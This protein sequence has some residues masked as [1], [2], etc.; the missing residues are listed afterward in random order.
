MIKSVLSGAVLATLL[1]VQP[2]AAQATRFDA[3]IAAEPLVTDV[4][5]RPHGPRPGVRPGFRGGPRFGYRGGGPRYGYR[6]GPRYGYGGGYYRH[7]RGWG[8][9]AA[10]GVAGLAAG[11]LIGSAIAS[12]PGA[13]YVEGGDPEAYCFRRFKSY[14]PA[15]GTYLGYDGFRHPCP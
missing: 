11:A 14:D 5:F 1:A 13:V 12:Q 8:G 15:S 3:G 4:Q 6:G 7:H 2:A 10:A 9:A